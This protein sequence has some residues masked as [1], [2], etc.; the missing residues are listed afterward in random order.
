MTAYSHRY[1]QNPEPL[2]QTTGTRG[3]AMR[4]VVALVLTVHGL[5]H[6]F[7][8]LEAFQFADVP[9]LTGVTLFALPEG[10]PVFSGHSG[11]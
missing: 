5:I 9:Q 8:F 2:V 6:I 11:P 1:H 7:G 4:F 3:C 10:R